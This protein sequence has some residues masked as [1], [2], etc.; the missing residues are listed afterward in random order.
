ML[1]ILSSFIIALIISTSCENKCNTTIHRW[2][3]ENAPKLIVLDPLKERYTIGETLR[4]RVQLPSENSFF[5]EKINL[6][7]ESGDST[8]L[9]TP[10]STDFL[11]SNDYK[12]IKGFKEVESEGYAIQYSKETDMYELE[13]QIRLS[14]A[15]VYSITN[16]A[17]ISLGLSECADYSL[18]CRYNGVE[19]GP[20]EFEVV[21]PK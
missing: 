12:L 17:E 9:F 16:G 3:D 4:Y 11:N 8:A 13:L 18:V 10:Y 1:K 2:G 19:L 20:V 6:L 5:G 15:G 7:S 14:S 21:E